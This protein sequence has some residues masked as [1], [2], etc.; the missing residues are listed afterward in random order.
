MKEGSSCLGALRRAL[1]AA[2]EAGAE[3]GLFDLREQMLPMYVPGK[4]LDDYGPKVR[5]L[6]RRCAG[7]TPSSSA[8]PPTTGR[9]R[10]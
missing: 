3:V 4:A 9:S 2:E 7:R 6:S 10:A 8:R 5:R 1:W